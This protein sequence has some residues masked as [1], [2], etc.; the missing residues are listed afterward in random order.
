VAPGTVG[1]TPVAL[2]TGRASPSPYGDAV[3]IAEAPPVR[4]A[5]LGSCVTR[6]LFNRTF[7]PHYRD[8]FDCV[9]LGNQMSLISLMSAAVDVAP[10]DVAV[11]DDLGRREVLAEASRAFLGELVRARPEYLIIDLFADVHF[12]CFEVDGKYLTRNRWKILKTGFYQQAATTDLLP[13]ADRGAYL[14]VWRR[15]VD[16]FLEFMRTH[17]PETRLVVH[18]SRNATRFAT[19]EGAVRDLGGGADLRAMNEWWDVLDDE[20][21]RRGIDRVIDVFTPDL[22]SFQA[23]P[24]GPFPV[25]YTLDYHARA[26]SRLTQIV[27]ADSRGGDSRPPA[28]PGDRPARA[29]IRTVPVPRMWR[30]RRRTETAAV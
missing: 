12:G 2:L 29:G 7:N 3:S 19:P 21:V 10:E 1:T 23:H 24:W 27:L 30:G 22:I 28:L 4:I 20:L 25:H 11:L 14:E 26:L 8:L 5:V 13:L 17:L 16:A 18:R 15:S 9:V 6:D